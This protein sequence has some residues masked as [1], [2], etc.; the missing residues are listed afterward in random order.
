MGPDRCE[1]TS[2]EF[3]F[4]VG[5]RSPLGAASVTVRF[6]SAAPERYDT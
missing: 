1:Q 3:K 5:Y 2:R 6:W 4:V